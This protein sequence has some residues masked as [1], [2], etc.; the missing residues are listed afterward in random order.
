MSGWQSLP[1]KTVYYDSAGKMVYGERSIDGRQYYFDP[2][3][4]ALRQ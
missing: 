3:T 4:G 1:G 2:V